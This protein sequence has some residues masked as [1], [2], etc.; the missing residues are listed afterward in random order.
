MI[1]LL[2]LANNDLMPPLNTKL[3][4]LALAGTIC[5]CGSIILLDLLETEFVF[6]ADVKKT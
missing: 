3:S 5:I 1:T 6:P 4:Q 2:S